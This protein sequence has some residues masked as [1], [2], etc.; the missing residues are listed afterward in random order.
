MSSIHLPASLKL[1]VPLLG[2]S[3]EEAIE[4]SKNDLEAFKRVQRTN[5]RIEIETIQGVDGVPI[6]GHIVMRDLMKT[7]TEGSSIDERLVVGII[8]TLKHT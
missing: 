6:L 2:E 3:F 7:T 5:F 8:E 4:G 1:Q